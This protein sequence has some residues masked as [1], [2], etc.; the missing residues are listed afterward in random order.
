MWEHYAWTEVGAKLQFT[1]GEGRRRVLLK[2]EIE[3]YEKLF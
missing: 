2:N 3:M 1:V